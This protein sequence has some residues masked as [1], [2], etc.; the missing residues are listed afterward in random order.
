MRIRGRRIV[1]T[2]PP[3]PPTSSVGSSEDP[4]AQQDEQEVLSLPFNG[5]I[6]MSYQRNLHDQSIKEDTAGG[7]TEDA[8]KEISDSYVTPRKGKVSNAVVP[9]Q[10]IV[11]VISSDEDE[12][13]LR[14]KKVDPDEVTSKR[15][16][17]RIDSRDVNM[18][19]SNCTRNE[20]TQVGHAR[21]RASGVARARGMHNLM[22]SRPKTEEELVKNVYGEA[23]AAQRKRVRLLREFYGV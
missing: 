7:L 4:P 1:K 3:P 2:P 13:A 22:P 23:K 9:A 17:R 14:S 11:I 21:V 18:R 19:R 12:P 10:Q 20:M 15:I 16:R 5:A 6:F 8:Y